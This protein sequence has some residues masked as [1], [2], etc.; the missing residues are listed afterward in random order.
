MHL[1]SDP[2]GPP[3]SVD[4][5]HPTDV[6]ILALLVDSPT[7]RLTMSRLAL[8]LEVPTGAFGEIVD[9]LVRD[10][11]GHRQPGES[12]HRVLFAVLTDR[13]GQVVSEA[14][15]SCAAEPGV[16]AE[17]LPPGRRPGSRTGGRDLLAGGG[18]RG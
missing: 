6:E 9:R 17:P 7:R 12:D 13:G 5:P 1:A 2:V 10:D 16:D 3:D 4:P 18:H 11:L 8:L 15:P 14:L